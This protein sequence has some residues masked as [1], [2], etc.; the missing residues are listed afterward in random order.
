MRIGRLIYGRVINQTITTALELS[1][2]DSN[3]NAVTLI[4]GDRINITDVVISTAITAKDVI[5][6][7]DHDGSNDL[8][9]GE[10][11]LGPIEFSDQGTYGQGF[12][13]DL[14]CQRINAALTNGIFLVADTTGTVSA[15]IIAHL[16]TT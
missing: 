4:E 15:T 9:A 6:F 8:D 14:R 5:L 13:L 11:L 2:T 16:T 3:G 1:W 10:H 7:Q 12:G